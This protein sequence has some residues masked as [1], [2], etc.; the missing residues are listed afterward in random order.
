MPRL[1]G[2]TV[3]TM[4]RRVVGVLAAVLAASAVAACGPDASPG[5]VAGAG[6]FPAPAPPAPPAPPRLPWQVGI[7][8]VGTT[9]GTPGTPTPSASTSPGLAPSASPALAVGPC[10]PLYGP[11]TPVPVEVRAVAGGAVLTWWHNGDPAARAYWIG[12]HLENEPP[13]IY[14]TGTPTATATPTTGPTATPTGTPTGVTTGGAPPA[15][16]GTVRWT[17]VSP[18][19]GCRF[20]SFTVTG[21]TPGVAYGMLLDL[22]ATTPETVGGVSQVML[23]QVRGVIPR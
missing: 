9:R 20:V 13:V 12:V 19:G 3:L 23:T 2:M 15:G 10:L 18:P 7:P 16:A 5:R 1:S 8:A 6:A 14:R 21:L 11:G 22:E 4:R 17:K